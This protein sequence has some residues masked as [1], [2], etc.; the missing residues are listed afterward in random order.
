MIEEPATAVS[1]STKSEVP[2]AGELHNLA[3]FTPGDF[4]RGRGRLTEVAWYIVK[5]VFFSTNAPWPSRLKA[6]WLRLFGADVG[7]GLYIRPRVNIHFPWKL[8]LGDHVWIGEGCTILNLERVVLRDHVALA[9]EVY[10]AA[11]GHDIASRS[12]RY[13]HGPVTINSG[14]WIATRAY[15]GPAVEI[16]AGAVVAPAAAVV[17]DVE[18]YA[19]VGG[20]PARKIGVRRLERP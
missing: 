20:V 11:A 12:L 14:V 5:M 19:I 16:G 15:V 13:R 9:H 6:M 7:T 4:D 2:P 10:I 3:A 8:S 1:D 18:P 17:G